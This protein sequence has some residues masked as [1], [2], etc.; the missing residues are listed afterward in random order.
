MK[1]LVLLILVVSSACAYEE[2]NMEKCRATATSDPAMQSYL[3]TIPVKFTSGMAC[4]DYDVGELNLV[5]QQIDHPNGCYISKE[6]RIEVTTVNWNKHPI[7]FRYQS[8][9]ERT[10]VHEY[11]HAIQLKTTGKMW[12]PIESLI[13]PKDK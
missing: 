8:D 1:F 13:P 12:H 9:V 6:N 2:A 10:L 7:E 11:T 5:T 4:Y 3:A